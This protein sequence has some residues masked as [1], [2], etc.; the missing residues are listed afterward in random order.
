MRIGLIKRLCGVTSADAVVRS[1]SDAAAEAAKTERAKMKA[2]A[3]IEEAR[4]RRQ[5]DTTIRKMR[6]EAL[7][8]SGRVQSVLGLTPQELAMLDDG[9]LDEILAIADADA[10]ANRRVG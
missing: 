5:T 3:V 2:R 8:A 6:V 10:E 9:M 4:R 1:D 7:G